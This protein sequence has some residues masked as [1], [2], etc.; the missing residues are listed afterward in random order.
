[1]PGIAPEIYDKPFEQRRYRNGPRDMVENE[2]GLLLPGSSAMIAFEQDFLVLPIAA[3]GVTGWKVDNDGALT[4]ALAHVAAGVGGSVV[5]VPGA[6]ATNNAHY[7][8]ANNTTILSPFTLSATKRL[9]L[10][11]R[12]KCEDV[13]KNLPIIG[14]HTS[15]TDP[16]ATEPADQF[17]FRALGSDG[18]L[19]FAAGTTNATE[20]TAVL[21]T[22]ADDTFYRVEAFYDG[23]GYARCWVWNDAGDLLAEG[24]VDQSA[25]YR[26]D[27]AMTVA[28]GME[29]VDTGADDMTI[30]YLN[31]YMER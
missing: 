17:L 1:M 22:M 30:D 15:Q 26:P 6:T 11:A 13:D 28:F 19:Q 24:N 23:A 3:S 27:G 20:R 10:K 29:M 5:F 4:T 31:V 21:N 8:W 25:T 9:W 14:L 2:F 18:I 7:Q 16:W 12:F